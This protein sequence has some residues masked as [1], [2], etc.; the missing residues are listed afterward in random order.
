M[1]LIIVLLIQMSYTA[2]KLLAMHE[3]SLVKGIFSNLKKKF[4]NK[5]LNYL[6]GIRLRL[7]LLSNAEPTLMRNA[8][9]AFKI[10]SGDLQNAI[11][12]IESLPIVVKCELCGH[13]SE[14]QSYKFV[15]ENCKQ[16]TNNIVSGL[17][18]E[19]RGLEFLK[20]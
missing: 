8:F 7:G 12:K 17:E 15:C 6:V 18:M 13:K 4:S 19:I 11:L 14:I 2:C 3:V 9:E 1:T 16:P 5:E 10:E 20:S